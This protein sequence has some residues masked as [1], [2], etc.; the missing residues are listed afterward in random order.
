VVKC[1]DVVSQTKAMMQSNMTL[2]CIN[3]FMWQVRKVLDNTAKLLDVEV[4]TS[5][6]SIIK[7]VYL[8]YWKFEVQPFHA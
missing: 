4:M 7:T 3:Y 2:T 5:I 8:P 1:K 6:D